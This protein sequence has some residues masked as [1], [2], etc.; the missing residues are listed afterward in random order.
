MHITSLAPHLAPPAAD[1]LS[2]EMKD[3][4]AAASATLDQLLAPVAGPRGR[5]MEAMRYSALDGGKRFRPFLVVASSDLF[6]VPRASSLRVAAALE[7]IHC[8]SLIHDD[9]P[10]MDNADLRRGRASNHKAFGEA[11]AIL[12]GDGLL[13]YA[14]EV[15]AA[16]ATHPN[17]E[18]RLRLIGELAR[19]AGVDGMVGGQMLDISDHRAQFDMAGISELQRLKTGA[20]IRFGCRA[21][22]IL[23]QAPYDA[24]TALDKYALDM[25]LA[26]QVADDILDVTTS[27]EA[28]GKPSAQDEDNDKATFVRM[29]GLERARTFAQ[30]LVE[31]ACAHLDVFGSR[32]AMLAE[33]ARFSVNRSS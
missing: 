16:P 7:M 28:L 13:T 5:V 14:F 30:E 8:Y 4:A 15:L 23:A 24:L 20:L 18:V 11:V 3:I 31:S 9:L 6:D 22:A 10:A 29:L 25:G 2:A 27:T 12:A 32:G 19:G 21:G 17:A 1:A 33:A 26:F